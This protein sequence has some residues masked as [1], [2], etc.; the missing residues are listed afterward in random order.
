MRRVAD[1][2]GRK[3]QALPDVTFVHVVTG[4]DSQDLAYTIIRNKAL[5]NNSMLF[6]E[7][8]RRIPDNDTLTVVRGYVGSYPNAFSRIPIDEIEDRIERFL[9]IKDKLDYYTFAKQYGIQRNSPIFWQESDWHYR[10]FLTERPKAAGLFDLYR[11]HRIAETSD[12]AF[13]W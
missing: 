13:S 11:F 7:D 6:R 9:K 12:A 3:V 1:I 5:S 10:K 2:H 8:R 4:E